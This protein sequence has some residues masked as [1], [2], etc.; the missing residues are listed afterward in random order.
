[1]ALDSLSEFAKTD[2]LFI[3]KIKMKEYIKNCIHEEEGASLIKYALLVAFIGTVTYATMEPQAADT[4]QIPQKAD[5]PQIKDEADAPQT[6]DEA[7]IPQIKE[8]ADIPQIKEEAVSDTSSSFPFL[9]TLA[10]NISYATSNLNPEQKTYTRSYVSFLGSDQLRSN[11][12][13]Q[14]DCW[15]YKDFGVRTMNLEGGYFKTAESYK[16]EEPGEPVADHRRFLNCF[17]YALG[18][19]GNKLEMIAGKSMEQIQDSVSESIDAAVKLYFEPISDEPEDGDLIIY[20][21][22]SGNNVHAGIYRKTA[23]LERSAHGGTI[24]SK[25]GGWGLGRP[26]CTFVFQHDIFFVPEFYG[27]KAKFYSLKTTK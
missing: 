6:K 12:A 11:L 1:M 21:N 7:D 10:G 14:R 18:T 17:Q 20:E 15:G 27:N 26:P 5:A 9:G 25:W 2:F 19:F 8:E 4:P 13:K 23:P 16:Y 22:D 24:V 3:V